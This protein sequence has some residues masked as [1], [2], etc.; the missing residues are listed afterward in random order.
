[1]NRNA[2]AHLARLEP[3]KNCTYSQ[4]SLYAVAGTE[5]IVTALISVARKDR[6]AAHHGTLRRARKKASGSCWRRGAG[7]A[8]PAPGQRDPARM[9]A[10]RGDR[11]ARGAPRVGRP[12]RCRDNAPLARPTRCAS[13]E[14]LGAL[15]DR[16]VGVL[17]AELLDEH[18]VGLRGDHPVELAAVRGHEAHA[19]DEDVVDE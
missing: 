19:V 7:A 11:T 4:L 15:G 14:A 3:T 13:L 9:V 8:R 2:T 17:P 6:H 16:R 18:V 12:S 1:M 5:M 10:P